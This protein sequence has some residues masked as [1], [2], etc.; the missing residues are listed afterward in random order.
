MAQ[1]QFST[2]PLQVVVVLVVT[3]KALQQV[4]ADL[5]AVVVEVQETPARLALVT[6]ADILPSKDM[7]VA[8]SQVAEMVLAVVVVQVPSASMV[9][10]HNQVQAVQVQP[11]VLLAQASHAQ[12]AAVAVDLSALQH[13]A[14]VDLAAAV[15]AVQIFMS[16]DL[17]DRK[18]R[19]QAAAVLG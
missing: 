16:Q 2:Q 17:P 10:R 8:L 7:A 15:Q 9:H 13:W 12:A 11:Q 1:I 19:A 14:Q 3:I 6:L 18:T 5:V 4:M